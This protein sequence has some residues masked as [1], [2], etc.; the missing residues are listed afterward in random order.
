VSYTV[1][2]KTV[3]LPAPLTYPVTPPNQ[4]PFGRFTIPLIVAFVT[5]SFYPEM[6]G[7]KYAM[8]FQPLIDIY[9]RLT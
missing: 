6:H 2:A 9:V 1:V 5:T 7:S 3:K 4:Q 8:L